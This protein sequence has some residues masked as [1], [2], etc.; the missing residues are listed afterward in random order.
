MY[1]SLEFHVHIRPGLHFFFVFLLLGMTRI[2]LLNISKFSI[3]RSLDDVSPYLPTL[4][5]NLWTILKVEVIDFLRREEWTIILIWSSE[6]GG[7]QPT[8]ACSSN[9]IKVIRKSHILSIKLLHAAKQTL[10]LLAEEEY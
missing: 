5:K 2:T 3:L 10:L 4:G 6:H 8:S 9:N 7:H 1:H